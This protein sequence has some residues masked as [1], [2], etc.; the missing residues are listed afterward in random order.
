MLLFDVV[1]P[2]N[3]VVRASRSG[4][5]GTHHVR[6]RLPFSQP[7]RGPRSVLNKGCRRVGGW[8]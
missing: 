6:F 4:R 5:R 8:R 2:E 7:L 1:E 3:P